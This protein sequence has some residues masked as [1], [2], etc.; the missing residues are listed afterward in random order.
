MGIHAGAS[1][2]TQVT[3]PGAASN[4]RAT[5]CRNA[6]SQAGTGGWAEI[7]D[8]APIMAAE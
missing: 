8:T 1:S 3:R 7:T 2:M 5:N 4:K 6:C